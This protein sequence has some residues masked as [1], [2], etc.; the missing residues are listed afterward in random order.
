MSF[1][2]KGIRLHTQTNQLEGDVN[3]QREMRILGWELPLKDVEDV[4]KWDLGE[5]GVDTPAILVAGKT[6]RTWEMKS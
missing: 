2:G 6:P 3:G 5:E 4:I 1:I